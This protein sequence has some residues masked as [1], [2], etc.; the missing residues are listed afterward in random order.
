[1]YAYPAFA[2]PTLVYRVDG[3][4]CVTFCVCGFFFTVNNF[5]KQKKKP[6]VFEPYLYTTDSIAALVLPVT[7]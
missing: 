3:F 1:M 7:P 6:Y 5:N 2:L 4:Y